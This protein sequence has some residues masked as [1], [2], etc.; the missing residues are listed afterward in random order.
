M[1]IEKHKYL[2]MELETRTEEEKIN[3]LKLVLLAERKL[4]IQEVRKLIDEL[5]TKVMR[6]RG[7]DTI[8]FSVDCWE[9]RIKELK[10]KL[11][12]LEENQEK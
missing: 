8:W 6:C 1:V 11:A 10:Q 4:I 7:V 12:K 9:H 3:F 2:I 5:N